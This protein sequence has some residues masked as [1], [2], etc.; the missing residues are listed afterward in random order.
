M[1]HLTQTLCDRCH[2][3]KE[4]DTYYFPKKLFSSSHVVI[5]VEGCSVYYDG[6]ESCNIDLCNSCLKE[7]SDLFKD[8]LR[9]VDNE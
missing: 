4:V 1:I 7:L 3:A 2:S 8:F 9:G 6:S 5:T